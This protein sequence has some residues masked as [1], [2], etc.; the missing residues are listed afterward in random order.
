MHR[1]IFRRRSYVYHHQP[2]KEDKV[3]IEYPDTKYFSQNC[4]EKDEHP[5]ISLEDLEIMDEES[6]KVVQNYQEQKLSM[7]K[8]IQDCYEEI[9]Q[10]FV[11]LLDSVF[12]EVFDLGNNHSK[13][14]KFEHFLSSF[15]D[16][17][18]DYE[19]QTSDENQKK[20]GQSLRNLVNFEK[21]LFFQELTD[22]QSIQKILKHCQELFQNC[23]V[24]EKQGLA[25]YGT[26]SKKIRERRF[27]NENL[28]RVLKSSRGAEQ[29]SHIFL[30]GKSEISEILKKFSSFEI[31]PENDSFPNKFGSVLN[32]LTTHYG[33]CN[34]KS[35]FYFRDNQILAEIESP[36]Q[37]NSLVLQEINENEKISELSSVPLKEKIRRIQFSPSKNFLGVEEIGGS[38]IFQVKNKKLVPLTQVMSHWIKSFTFVDHPLGESLVFISNKGKFSMFNLTQKRVMFFMK[39]SGASSVHYLTGESVFLLINKKEFA[40]FSLREFAMTN[41]VK[42][43][44]NQTW[45]NP[46]LISH[47]ISPKNDQMTLFS[48]N[49][50]YFLT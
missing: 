45:E 26:F 42:F 49:K 17:K 9:K 40:V 47:R 20:L 16:A 31:K 36:G 10:K 13:Y 24:S 3:H 15:Q 12:E 48:S 21:S 8:Q 30:H 7:T 33:D 35:L 37:G 28:T 14:A 34:L 1:G 11:S 50:F 25:E 2:S 41:V 46:Y 18:N 43:L 6:E 19:M 5:E 29:G 23:L 22:S 38:S 39:D 27:N 32:N 4:K 44:P